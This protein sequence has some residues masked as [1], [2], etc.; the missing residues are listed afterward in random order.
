VSRLARI[1]LLASVMLCV[2]AP[3]ASAVPT[4]TPQDTLAELWTTV[5]QTPDAKN[6]FGTGGAAYACWK[7]GGGTV[8]PLAPNG[9]ESCTVKPDTPI[10]VSVTYECSTFPGDT[11]GVMTTEAKLRAC[12]RHNDAQH[13]PTVTVDGQPVSVS[14]VETAALPIVLPNK[15]IFGLPAGTQGISVAHGWVALLPPLTVGQHTI[16]INDRGST[17]TTTITVQ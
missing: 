17:I 4:T 11:P 3:A 9:V 8:A 13:A 15:N 5:L 6:S 1:L 12:A 16:V 7:L 2:A 14:E 10:F